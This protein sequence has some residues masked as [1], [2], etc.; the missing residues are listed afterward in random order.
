MAV[1]L[2]RQER[3]GLLVGIGL[4]VAVRLLTLGA[5]PV[6]DSTESRYAEIARKMLE[7]GHWLMPQFAYG[8]PFWGKPPLSTWLSAASMWAL[9][10]NEFA[11]RLPSLLLLSGSGAL[12]IMLARR[13]AGRDAALLAGAFFA[14]TLCVFV[15]AGAVMTDAALLLGTT[16]S[17]AGFWVAANSSGPPQRVAGYAFFVGLAIG[18]M[19]KGPVALVLTFVPIG[20]WTL[21]TRSWRPGVVTSAMGHGNAAGG[22]ARGA[23]VPGG[24]ARDARVSRILSGRRALEALRRARLEGGPLRRGSRAPARIDLAVLDRGGIAM[25]G[26]GDRLAGARGV[27]SGVTLCRPS[28]GIRGSRTCC[29]GSITPMLFF[30]LAGNILATYVLPGIPAFALLLATVWRTPAADVR[31]VRTPARQG[32]AAAAVLSVLAVGV[33]VAMGPRFEA[34]LSQRKL[35]RTYESARASADERLVYIAKMPISA[36]FYSHGKAILVRD[37]A[38]A[39]P[40]LSDGTR[41]FIAVRA[42]GLEALPPEVRARLMDVGSFGD[43]RLWREGPG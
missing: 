3:R 29:C 19:A 41:D 43:Y 28:P 17:M 13:R 35:V 39:Q 30:T 32:I 34:E 31:A 2:T 15:A 40:Y 7:T 36:E 10:V 24:G 21:W 6:M 38:G 12:V 33:V 23:V 4:L 26:T 18:A 8:V 42:H 9:G 1:T 37:A 16:L 20:A 11:A 22:S 27:C 5:Y 14:T 25:V